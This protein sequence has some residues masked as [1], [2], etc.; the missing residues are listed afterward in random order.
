MANF[1][2]AEP[3]LG[4]GPTPMSATYT[5]AT[6]AGVYP[7]FPLGY[8]VRA[9]DPTLGAGIFVH[10]QGS[11]I[12]TAG[13]VVYLSNGTQAVKLGAASPY[14]V[15][16]AAGAL[17]ATNVAGWVQ[18]QGIKDDARGT[19][20]S[21]TATNPLFIG[22]AAGFVVSG[23][24]AG[25]RIQNMVCAANYNTTNSLSMSLYLDRPYVQFLTASM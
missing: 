4:I 16:V 18:I 1:V 22:T 20:V 11:D 3:Q 6:S 9:E 24:V 25:S 2:F 13:L 19:N 10:A 14:P 15:G 12:G 7:S 8:E 23:S 17:S 21:L 5:F